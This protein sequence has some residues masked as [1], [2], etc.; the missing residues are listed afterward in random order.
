MAKKT[1]QV[2]FNIKQRG[3]GDMEGIWTM[4]DNSIFAVI[5]ITPISFMELN[6]A[7]QKE[8][9]KKLN[10]EFWMKLDF[11]VK[12]LVRPVNCSSDKKLTI[13]ES[14]LDYNIEKTNKSRLINHYQKFMGWFKEYASRNVKEGS[15]YYIVVNYNSPLDFKE[16]HATAVNVL[17]SRIEFVINAL[18]N[19]GMP[20]PKLL[21][22]HEIVRIYDSFLKLHIYANNMYLFPEDWMHQFKKE[23]EHEKKEESGQEKSQEKRKHRKK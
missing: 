12:I 6:E 10:E 4:T 8:F 5:E 20:E 22:T 3:A 21:T 1:E 17:R 7:R 9:K 16:N 15:K 2:V 14:L 18:K 13:I 11:P 23:G 19:M